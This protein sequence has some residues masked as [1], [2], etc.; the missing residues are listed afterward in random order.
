MGYRY[1]NAEIAVERTGHG[2]VVLRVLLERD[3]PKIYYH[4][5]PLDADAVPNE[6]GWKTS[7]RTKPM[8]VDGL[9]TTIRANDIGIWSLNL[10]DE[11]S[12]YIYDGTS[13]KKFKKGWG[14]DDDELD[15]LMIAL[16]VREQ[17]P[18]SDMPRHRPESYA[19]IM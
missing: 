4:I 15:A 13:D 16:Q 7:L 18:I 5:D 10:C 3:Y 11:A 1:N 12:S 2:L 14:A 17:T 6:P 8:M 9:V 19:T